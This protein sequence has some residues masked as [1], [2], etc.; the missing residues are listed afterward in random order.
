MDSRDKDEAKFH[1]QET[2][3]RRIGKAL[4]EK[5][6]RNPADCPDGEI[7]AAYADRGLGTEQSAKW[8]SHFAAC[9]RCRRILL[10]LNASADTPLAEREV[11]RLGELASTMGPRAEGNRPASALAWPTLGDW[12]LRWLAP[13]VGVAAV[14]VVFVAL[15]SNWR[16]RGGA[17]SRVLVAQIPKEEL[18]QTSA[19]SAPA[20]PP[21]APRA[22]PQQPLNGR[23]VRDRKETDEIQAEKKSDALQANREIQPPPALAPASGAAG[24]EVAPQPPP[25]PPPVKAAAPNMSAPEPNPLDA[26]GNEAVALAPRAKQAITPQAQAA[27]NA[28]GGLPQTQASSEARTALRKDQAFAL[29]APTQKA[30]AVLKTLSGST[31]WR[32]G[33]GGKIE[34]STDGGATWLLQ[35]SPSQEDWLAGAAVSDELC[36]LV[37]R[38]GA[39]AR[40]VDGQHWDRVS[41]PPMAAGADGVL[42]DWTGIVASDS[43]TATIIAAYGRRFTTADGGQTWQ[44]AAQ[45]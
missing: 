28:V 37:G 42:P 8:E 19:P 34:R 2:L 15:R 32:A 12:R 36:W 43:Q 44:P 7:L 24:A 4:D 10:V 20:T 21:P 29:A 27:T 33:V 3:G 35:T 30:P 11:A 13:A 17:D 5:D 41:P 25:A 23:E 14:L 26:A 9:A 16:G 38:R 18:P 39:I 31:M 1:R 22:E 6:S 45:K 40:T